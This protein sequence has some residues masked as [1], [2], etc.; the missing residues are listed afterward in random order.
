M[1]G[2]EAAVSAQ[3]D[4]VGIPA[5]AMSTLSF[6]QGLLRAVSADNVNPQAVIQMERLGSCFHSNGPWAAKVPDLLCRAS[7]V[8]L[9]RLFA[10]I[11]WEKNDTASFKSK[12]TGGKTASLL[13]CVLGS[14]YDPTRCGMLLHAL[15]ESILPSEQQ[16]AS[17]NQLG[18][19]CRN[20]EGKLACLGFGNHFAIQATRLRQCF[21][22][23][24]LAVPEDLTKTP[25]G[26]DIKTFLCNVCEALQD[27]NLILQVT[28]TRCL[29]TL[30]AV[31]LAICPDDTSVQV[32]GE[33]LMTGP[34]KNILFHVTE[35]HSLV[36]EIHIESMFRPQKMDFAKSYIT[37]NS[38][39]RVNSNL[40]FSFDN[41]LSDWL[42]LTLEITDK[43]SK[44][45]LKLAIANV[46][47]C[48]ASSLTGEQ[49][50]G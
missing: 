3:A 29:A 21:F 14:L 45:S 39:E 38:P 43:G 42:D 17:P 26:E 6:T 11:G 16:I 30:L 27:E 25:T 49:L 9:E 23:A 20:L 28:G 8:R 36:T 4:I 35:E 12:T 15:S 13:C 2:D 48:T 33:V 37:R 41:M 1:P 18:D 24:G 7:S 10:W 19:V 34:R 47:A 31:V 44:Q 32:N 5:A 40:R 50:Q 22:E 46:V